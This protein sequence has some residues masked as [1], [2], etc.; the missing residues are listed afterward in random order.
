MNQGT[1]EDREWI[2]A[3]RVYE[4]VGDPPYTVDEALDM[5]RDLDRAGPG[6]FV[7]MHRSMWEQ[8]SS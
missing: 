8:V 7:V 1:D 4:L 5:K 3:R 6:E 2:V